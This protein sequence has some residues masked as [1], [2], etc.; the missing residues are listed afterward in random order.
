MNLNHNCVHVDFWDTAGDELYLEIR[1]EFYGSYDALLL[2]FDVAN[3]KSFENLEKWLLEI[4]RY[5]LANGP[6]NLLGKLNN[7][8]NNERKGIVLGNKV[9]MMMI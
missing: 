1:N 8:N 4:E 5:S 2:V 3:A 6:N 7:N 9:I